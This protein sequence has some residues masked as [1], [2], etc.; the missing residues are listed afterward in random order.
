MERKWKEEQLERGFVGGWGE[1]VR[2][3]ELGSYLSKAKEKLLMEIV[4]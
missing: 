4:E 3:V 1:R 2:E